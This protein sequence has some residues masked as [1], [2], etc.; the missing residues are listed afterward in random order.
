MTQLLPDT[1]AA[2]VDDI[3]AANQQRQDVAAQAARDAEHSREAE[4]MTQAIFTSVNALI[5]AIKG[6][7]TKAAA[8]G[9]IVSNLEKVD[10]RLQGH[11]VELQTLDAAFNELHRQLQEVPIDD[12]KQLPKFLQERSD[13]KVTNLEGIESTLDAVLKAV[14]ALKLH[15]DAPNVDVKAPNVHV[16]A[17]QVHVPAVDLSGVERAVESLRTE[18]TGLK[19]PKP[20][21]EHGAMKTHQV[22][23]LITEPFDEYKMQY[24]DFDED[25]IE[26][27]LESISYWN[28]GKKVATLKLSYDSD[29]NLTGAKK[30]LP[31]K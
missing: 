26:P 13:V 10:G 7:T 4:M 21:Y 1:N 3:V 11:D 8:I 25:T 28:N 20:E 12:L 27:R 22:N 23:S 24:D 16:D 17:P 18:I 9:L 6:D 19:Q 2:T 31:K 30:A 29:G 5:G 15:V 14:K